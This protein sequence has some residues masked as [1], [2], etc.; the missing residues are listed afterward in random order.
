MSHQGLYSTNKVAPG[1]RRLIQYEA[2]HRY[3]KT[4]M[5]THDQI[6]VGALAV[7][8]LSECQT[9]WRWPLTTFLSMD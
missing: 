7:M 5:D 9:P 8:T 6:A 1:I 2:D 4:K 3:D